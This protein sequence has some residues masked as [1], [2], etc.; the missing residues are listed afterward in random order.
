MA[1]IVFRFSLNKKVG[2]NFDS[3]GL[4][5]RVEEGN[6]KSASNRTGSVLV[7]KI[8]T[9]FLLRLSFCG[10]ILPVFF[11]ELFLV[12]ISFRFLFGEAFGSIFDFHELIEGFGHLSGDHQDFSRQVVSYGSVVKTN[13]VFDLIN[14]EREVAHP[15]S[16]RESVS[17]FSE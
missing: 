5:R 2:L 15:K 17:Q 10:E 7:N 4:E 11:L 14:V 3:D 16:K 1:E 8:K 12:G 6:E 9:I 13:H